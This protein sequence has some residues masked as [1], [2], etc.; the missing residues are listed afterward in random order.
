MYRTKKETSQKK[1]N[2]LADGTTKRNHNKKDDTS[3]FVVVELMSDRE[4][5]QRDE[6]TKKRRN[7]RK[8][9]DKL[10]S[11]RIR[12]QIGDELP[13]GEHG[14]HGFEGNKQTEELIITTR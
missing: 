3:I 11:G 8:S 7:E 6:T 13:V 1:M 9:L 14:Q 10:L 2:A 5:N 12:S 4:L